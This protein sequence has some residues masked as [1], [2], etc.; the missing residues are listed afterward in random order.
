MK[1][2]VKEQE[3]KRKLRNRRLAA[4][5]RQRKNEEL[6][7]LRAENAELKQMIAMLTLPIE[8]Q[9]P[10]PQPPLPRI[11]CS[12]RSFL[13]LDHQDDTNPIIIE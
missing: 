7:R 2:T 1:L 11:D 10:L 13:G 12:F 4:E 5:S 9:L 3:E 6:C 8:D